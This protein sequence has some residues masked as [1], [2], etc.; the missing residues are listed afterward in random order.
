MLKLFGK[1][2]NANVMLTFT[3]QQQN[4]VTGFGVKSAVLLEEISAGKQSLMWRSNANERS[5]CDVWLALKGS[6][7]T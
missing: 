6:R 4:C 2:C 7:A 5:I 3:A 1:P